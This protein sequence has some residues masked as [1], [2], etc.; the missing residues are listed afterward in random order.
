RAVPPSAAPA[1]TS[2]SESAR[3]RQRQGFFEVSG[4]FWAPLIAL[5]AGLR[6]EEALQLRTADIA[7]MDGLPVIRVAW[8]SDQRKKS[9]SAR[10]GA[11]CQSI[12]SSSALACSTSRRRRARGV[13]VLF[14][15]LPR[16]KPRDTLQAYFS[17]RFVVLRRDLGI[18]DRHD[19]H[20]L[21]TTFDTALERQPT[22][23]TTLV[24]MAMGHSLGRDMASHYAKITP[25]DFAP[26]IES[27]DFGL[28]LT[29]LV[30]SRG[31]RERPFEIHPT[32]EEDQAKPDAC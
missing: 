18:P 6:M 4:W 19:F 28:D 17:R 1:L 16:T 22:T 13:R 23:N 12:L 8:S 5:Y 15:E 27:L 2:S 9:R 32:R 30:A 7:S 24:R 21:R 31:R 14:P 29:A 20:A 10:R 11:S 3:S 25:P 26:L